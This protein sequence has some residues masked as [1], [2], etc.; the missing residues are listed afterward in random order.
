[1]LGFGR[2]KTPAFPQPDGELCC[3]AAREQER[4]DF[5]DA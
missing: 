4:P 5:L 3:S 1:M 2:S